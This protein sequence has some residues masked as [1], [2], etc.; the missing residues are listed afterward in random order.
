MNRNVLGLSNVYLKIAVPF[1]LVAA[2]LMVAVLAVPS[3][4]GPIASYLIPVLFG[5]GVVLYLIGRVVKVAGV[6]SS[7]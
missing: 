7:R 1:L 5:G 4:R 2:G 6:R 3:M